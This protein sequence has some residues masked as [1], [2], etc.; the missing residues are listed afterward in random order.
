MIAYALDPTHALHSDPGHPEGPHRLNAVEDLLLEE[1]WVE[2]VLRAPALPAPPEALARVHAV[3]HVEL[4][5]ALCARGTASLDMD[6]Y[7]TAE[8]Y[9]VAVRAA[10][11]CIAITDAVLEGRASS[12]FA[13]VRPPGHHARPFAAMG[14]CLFNNV[15]VAARHA[16]AVHG[17]E[18]VLIVD[19]DVH[20]GNGTQEIFYDDPSVLFVSSHQYPYYPGTGAL[21]ETG[22]G[23]G[24]GFT[25]NLPLPGGTTDGP[26]LDL[27]RRVLLPLNDRF[28][29][30][31][32][33]LSAGYD[34]HRLDPL[35][36]L[37]LSVAGITDL[38]R[39][40]SE[41]AERWAGGRVVA[42][43]EGGY[44]PDALAHSVLSTFRVLDDPSAEASDPFGP[45]PRLGP[46]LEQL[47]GHACALHRL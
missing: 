11:G 15:A 32:V 28:R 27:Y 8:S 12:G 42:A 36:G 25:V 26:L 4:L 31:V 34:A 2:R 19:F 47:A 21:A 17:V 39:V 22:A 43:L 33:F 29:P 9:G 24:E 1:G 44:H 20:H 3:E 7:A 40:C 45:S 5:E 23:P 18:R 41:V 10:G 38:V 37:A 46:S 16:Q 6:T 14:F 30:E 35:G 13:L